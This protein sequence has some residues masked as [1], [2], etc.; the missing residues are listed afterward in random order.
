MEEIFLFV[1]MTADRFRVSNYGKVERL[2]DNVWLPVNVTISKSI[3]NKVGY[4]ICSVP[5]LYGS[6]SISVHRLVASLFLPYDPIRRIVNHKDFNTLNNRVDNLEY[7]TQ[8]ENCQYSA[9]NM[10]NAKQGEKHPIASISD[11]I[12][13]NI[14]RDRKR[15]M[16]YKKICEKYNI[17]MHTA[18]NVCTR[19]YSHLNDKV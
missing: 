16:R 1:P 5:F 9:K 12:A 17:P 4:Y 3:K 10:G 18:L 13:L 6:L 11:D 14:K 2:E 19:Y 7:V 15:G 8:S